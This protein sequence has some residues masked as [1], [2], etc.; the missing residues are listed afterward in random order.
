MRTTLTIDDDLLAAAKTLARER[1]VPVGRV[2][3]ELARKGLREPTRTR[4]RNGLPVFSLPDN[5]RAI[6]LEDVKRLEDEL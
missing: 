1:S 6:V 5:A 4:M 2:I 3:S